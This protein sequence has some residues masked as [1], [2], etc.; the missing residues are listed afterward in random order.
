MAV[1]PSVRPLAVREGRMYRD[2]NPKQQL[3]FSTAVHFACFRQNQIQVM[4]RL[5]AT[6]GGSAAVGA[7][8]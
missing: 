2:D 7:V 1:R 4:F 8:T 6:L 3:L 5:A